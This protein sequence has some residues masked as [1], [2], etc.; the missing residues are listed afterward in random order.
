MST[1]IFFFQESSHALLHQSLW[2]FCRVPSLLK[3]LYRRGLVL[4]A[5]SLKLDWPKFYFT[6]KPNSQ[7]GSLV[8]RS[9]GEAVDSSWNHCHGPQA[10][11]CN[12]YKPTQSLS[13]ETEVELQMTTRRAHESRRWLKAILPQR[14]SNIQ[15]HWPI[16]NTPSRSFN[17]R[18][19]WLLLRLS[20]L[21]I[22]PPDPESQN[23]PAKF[24]QWVDLLPFYLPS[25]Q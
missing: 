4:D 18:E 10:W 23:F 8:R 6:M 5:T 11:S 7:V 2:P 15:Q 9:R 12:I 13:Y 24:L 21:M 17:L 1:K 22:L 20:S 25:F 3:L 14:H 19:L 16:M